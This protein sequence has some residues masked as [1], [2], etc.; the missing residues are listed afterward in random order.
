VRDAE[1][2][3]AEMLERELTAAVAAKAERD[4]LL[5]RL[6]AAERQFAAAQKV[7]TGTA[8][9]LTRESAD[10]AGLESLSLTRLLASL[11]GSRATD[12]DSE[13]AQRKR[14][15]Y[16]HAVAVATRDA[17]A[18]D[19]R[20]VREALDGT[21][22]VENRFAEALRAKEAW[23]MASP[24]DEQARNL[25]ETAER[26]GRLEARE[27]E[28]Q[29]AITAGRQ[30]RDSL[31]QAQA[32]L[33]SANT[34]STIDVFTNGGVLADSVK[35]NQMERAGRQL[36]A[37]ETAMHTFGSELADV[38]G[39]TDA[40]QLDLTMTVLDTVFDNI[41]TD[42][43]VQ[44]RIADSSNLAQRAHQAV[45]E[46]VSELEDEL[47]TIQAERQILD[48]QRAVLLTAPLSQTD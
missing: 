40:L 7:V 14:A 23:L 18:A 20:R 38:G 33:S 22:G 48:E 21:F 12:L 27:I 4:S 1:R 30:A 25:T 36:H 41:F 5:R 10:V 37:A 6:D 26:R 46:K 9:L 28:T 8:Q 16:S 11:R 29:Q 19:R 15:E 3:D 47:I 24:D 13:R 17:A 45:T 34:W 43:T 42:L 39:A 31:S 35:R 44:N 32:E 2:L